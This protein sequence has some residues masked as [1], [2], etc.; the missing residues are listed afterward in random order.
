MLQQPRPSDVA[1]I[2]HEMSKFDIATSSTSAETRHSLIFNE[3]DSHPLVHMNLILFN[4]ENPLRDAM[5]KVMEHRHTI[6]FAA[7]FT[8]N[9][10]Q[11]YMPELIE[12]APSTEQLQLDNPDH[13]SKRQLNVLTAAYG[14]EIG[15]ADEVMEIFNPEKK[16]QLSM[17]LEY[18]VYVTHLQ[19]HFLP[20]DI[21]RQLNKYPFDVTERKLAEYQ[22]WYRSEWLDRKRKLQ[23]S[24]EFEDWE[25]RAAMSREPVEMKPYPECLTDQQP[26]E[27]REAEEEKPQQQAPLRDVMLVMSEQEE[28]DFRASLPSDVYLASDFFL[29]ELNK[30]ASEK[31]VETGMRQ[32]SI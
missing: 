24:R 30:K 1:N 5:Q 31:G 26:K 27:G 18:Q 23:E 2:L 16:T 21:A 12:F 4:R 15:S 25:I 11:P 28:A 7:L 19:R 3:N 10:A 8:A 32:M 17:P 13:A 14:D 22:Q 29:Q 20:L 6:P 9:S